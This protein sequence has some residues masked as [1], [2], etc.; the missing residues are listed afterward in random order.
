MKQGSIAGWTA[1]NC[2]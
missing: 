2:K 1:K